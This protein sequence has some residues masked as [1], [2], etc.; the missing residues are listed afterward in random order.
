MKHVDG[1]FYEGDLVR[2]GRAARKQVQIM[3]D[4]A[5]KY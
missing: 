3:Y 5:A 2:K 1:C 4:P